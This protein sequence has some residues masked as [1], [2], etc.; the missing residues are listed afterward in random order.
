MLY[1]KS[2]AKP[3]NSQGVYEHVLVAVLYYLYRATN[4]D[5]VL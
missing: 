5:H 4:C 2:V 3:I 1:Y